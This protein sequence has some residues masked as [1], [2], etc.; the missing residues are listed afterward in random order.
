MAARV[1][2]NEIFQMRRDQRVG[3]VL[4]LRHLLGDEE[5]VAA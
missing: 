2:T 3:S 4:K 1:A 5:A